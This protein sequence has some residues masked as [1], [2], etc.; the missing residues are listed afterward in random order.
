MK[1]VTLALALLLAPAAFAEQ[2]VSLPPASFDPAPTSMSERK[3]VLA[4]GCFWG[5]QGVFQHVKGVTRAVSGYAGG[6]RETAQYERVSGGD[7][8][9]AESVEIAYDPKQVSLGEL[10]RV[11]FSVAHDPTQLNAQG[12]DV[13]AQY[14]SAIFVADAEQE[15]IAR[16]YID[17]LSAARVFKAPIVTT[18]EPLKAFYPAEAYHQDYLLRNPRA[19]YIVHNDLPKIENLKRL[20]PMLYRETPSRAAP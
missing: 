18:L 16:A 4:G 8:G 7:T 6:A 3:L 12:P 1:R 17:Q 13:G 14:R 15:K 2:G 10:L 20:F 19:P 5:V 11:Y 9:H